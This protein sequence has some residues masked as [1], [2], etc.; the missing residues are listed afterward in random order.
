ME[1][2]LVKNSVHFGTEFVFFFLV[3]MNPP[4]QR[5]NHPVHETFFWVWTYVVARCDITR[6][7]F[8]AEYSTRSLSNLS[9]VVMKIPPPL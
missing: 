1:A 7:S 2:V 9:S 5:Q 4:G 6:V 8:T 3:W